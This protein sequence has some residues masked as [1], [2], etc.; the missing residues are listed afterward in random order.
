MLMPTNVHVLPGKGK[1]S[2]QGRKPTGC[3]LALAMVVSFTSC[4]SLTDVNAPDVVQP[5]ALENPTGAMALWAGALSRTTTA[6][7]QTVV[8]SGE[9]SDELISV[10]AAGSDA[11][12][13]RLLE[14]AITGLYP[15]TAMH[16]AHGAVLQAIGVAQRVAPQPASRTGQL[17]A[18]LGYIEL[19]FAEQVCS[20]VPLGA[21][22]DGLDVPGQPLTSAEMYARAIA[23]F[24]SSLV[25]T[26]DSARIGNFARVG[27]GRAMLGV[28]QYAN[29]RTAVAAVPTAYVYRTENSATV[30]L[31][32][33]YDA[34]NNGKRSSVA[35]RE[36]LNGLNFRTA[37]DPRVATQLVGKG[38]D[39]TSDLYAFTMYTSLASPIVVAS[40]TEARLIEAEALLNAGDAA[41]ALALLNTLRTTVTGLAPL[42]L[43]PD[44]ASRVDQ[45]FRERA[46][47]LFLTGHRQGDLRR[48]VRQYGRAREA[49]FPTGAYAKGGA[50]YGTDVTFAPEF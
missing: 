27:R 37:S 1:M 45:L 20:G 36:G 40:G 13:R 28:G 30:Q 17:F 7:A 14:P 39:G 24:D 35:D 31:N 50:T 4:S 47:W 8:S 19:S 34:I 42:T 11:D 46:F 49:V 21:I 10:T 22:H 26:V 25:Y 29:A 41:G 43:Q 33:V 5:A 3:M 2:W 12:R 15:Y 48:L 16:A 23:D 6:F 9:L 38:T 32:S 44:N 18:L